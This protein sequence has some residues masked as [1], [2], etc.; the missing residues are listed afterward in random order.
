MKAVIMAGGEGTRLRPLTS[1]QPKPMLPM[2]NI[3]MMEHVVN[4][5]RTHGFEDIVVTVAFMANAIRTYFGDGSE[6][7]VRMVYATESTPLGTAGSVRNAKDELDERFLVISGDVLTDIDLGA[8]VDFHDAHGALA[9]L[10][11][12]AV[13][14]PLEFGIVITNEDGSI[15]R[16]LEKPTWGQVFSDN[17]NTGIYVLEP[18]IFDFIDGG[19]PVDFSSE[20]FPEVLEAGRPIYGYVADGYW[21][22]VGTTEAYLKAHQDILDEKVQ[23]EID[24]FPLRTGVWL[25]RGTTVDPTATISGP[26]IIGPNC[27]IGPDAVLGE[28]TT[29]GSNIRVG[30]NAE[31]RR[32]VI[33]D[34]SYLGNGV[35][36]QGS[37]IGRS[38]DLREGTRCEPGSVLGEGC[39]IGAHAE[40]RAGVKV[41]PFK[42][43]ETGAVV[44]SSIIWESRGARLLF[45]RD[46]VRGIANI[47]ISPELVVRLSMAWAST[48]EKG[49]TITASRDT[50]RAARVLK[51]AVM[52]GCN[53]AGVN[54]E[55]LEVAT[56]PVTRHAVRSSGSNGGVTVRL[57]PDDPQSIVIRFFDDEGLD[58][59]E[60]AQRK[61]E[62]VYYREDF[63]RVL[64]GEIGEI[65][66]P[67]RTIEHYTAD[68]FNAVDLTTART[69]DLKLVLD[70]SFGAASFVMPNLLAKLD[71]DV[72]VV[73][74]YAHT[75]LMM[76]VD[77]QANA[78]RVADL[79]RAS[80]AQLGAVIDPDC[81][82]LTIVDDEGEVL[83]D[84]QALLTL[85]R[86][87]VE[88]HPGATVALPVAASDVA[89]AI[90]AEGGASI[91]FTKLSSAHL[92]EVASE[93]GVTFAA[94]QAGGFIFPD[95]LPAY[96]AATTLVELIALLSD[97]GQT[98]SK[99]VHSLPPVHIAHESVV[100]PWEQKGMIMRTLVEQ[101]SDRDLVLV[102]GVKVPEEDGWALVLPDPEEPVTHVW[103][104]GPSDAR[105]RTRAQQYAVR[106][107]QLLR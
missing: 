1:N 33:S 7:G 36:V 4:L 19:G 38:C 83:S 6:F 5:L 62:R 2:A 78:A 71:A 25:G 84:D 96:D 51:R 94:S 107:R 29:L 82:H 30:A 39:L 106:L 42:T 50:S 68:L 79:V 22:D 12:K 9:T 41:Y 26:A 102:D 60:N 14:N 85:L 52:V 72:L 67:G 40:L 49:S 80:G 69:T 37:L 100:T 58:I 43:V 101:L 57:A 46:G 53:A 35:R 31:V 56:V 17:I 27:S 54:V 11:L 18:E 15:E 93:G 66:F 59:P 65:D 45:G 95:F 86:L 28:Y 76:S 21:E 98:L 87:V 77:R 10:A 97:T 3:P 104:E 48:L 90:C 61:I 55:D 20:V 81:E 63:R 91:I 99:L 88:T 64:A 8:V 13:E 89:Q 24:G 47:D 16:F 73:N 105:A 23:I 75:S 103:A 32:S 44:N 34:N 74:P 92:M 70:L